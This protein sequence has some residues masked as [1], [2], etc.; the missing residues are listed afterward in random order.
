[1]SKTFSIKFRYKN[2]DEEH[3]LSEIPEDRYRGALF[4]Q[5][6][7]RCVGLDC[8]EI[9][10]IGLDYEELRCAECP[11][12]GRLYDSYCHEICRMDK[13]ESFKVGKLK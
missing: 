1:M 10:C 12:D 7:L 5:K 2:S 13:V 3:T 4:L 6:N 8:V 11:L 9:H